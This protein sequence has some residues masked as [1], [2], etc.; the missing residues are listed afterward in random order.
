VNSTEFST[1][2][3]VGVGVPGEVVV[4]ARVHGGTSCGGGGKD[5]VAA[6]VVAGERG[7]EVG[8]GSGIG[9]D[10]LDGKE[11]STPLAPSKWT[12][13]TVKLSYVRDVLCGE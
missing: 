5:L 7:A 4:A 13:S 11:L 9:V 12:Y 3:G 1:R 6:E 10:M 8:R 2:A